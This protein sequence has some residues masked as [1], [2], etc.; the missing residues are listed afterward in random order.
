MLVK[1]V[2]DDL[3]AVAGFRLAET[4]YQAALRAAGE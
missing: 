4:V 3:R 2:L 1:P